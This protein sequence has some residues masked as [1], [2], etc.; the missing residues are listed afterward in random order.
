VPTAAEAGLPGYESAAW[1]A[2]LAPARIDQALVDRLYAAA[3]EAMNDPKVR[4]LF[5]EQGAEATNLG[6]EDLRKFMASEILK[7]S[8]VIGKMGIAPM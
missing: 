6:P 7:W 8:D 5:A 2:L 3:Q 1:L 4:A